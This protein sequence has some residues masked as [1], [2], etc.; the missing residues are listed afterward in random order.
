MKVYSK[1][2][3]EFLKKVRKPL[4]KR[5]YVYLLAFQRLINKNFND[6][7]FL[8][9]EIIQTFFGKSNSLFGEV[10]LNICK[11]LFLNSLIFFPVK[12]SSLKVYRKFLRRMQ[13][14]RSFLRR[15]YFCKKFHLRCS[16]RF[17]IRLWDLQSFMNKK[18]CNCVN[19]KAI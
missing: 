18:F 13:R 17:W 8:F 4:F 7:F 19:G 6:F 9:K 16:T 15:Y 1:F 11:N 10:S 12:L 2:S 5:R 14:L 3:M